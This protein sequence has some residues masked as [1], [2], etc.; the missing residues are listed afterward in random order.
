M[1][2]FVF[3]SAL[4][5]GFALAQNAD[6]QRRSARGDSTAGQGY[7]RT[8]S[9]AG[10]WEIGTQWNGSDSFVNP[11]ARYFVTPSLAL[12]GGAEFDRLNFDN[13]DR[14]PST[15]V[16]RS[17][18]FYELKDHGR[19]RCYARPGAFYQ[20]D[21]FELG[22]DE[23]TQND[24]GGYLGIGGDVRITKNFLLGMETGARF[25]AFSSDVEDSGGNV[26]EGASGNKLWGGIYN[27][28]N[29]TFRFPGANR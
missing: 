3:I 28:I 18:L 20:R 29:A 5:V 22:G 25:S 7:A 4:L 9:G 2:R 24:I 8:M 16:V 23:V 27:R 26:T 13:S 15:L 6:A 17:G 12:E 14:D 21:V 19:T 11:Y 1:T 10:D